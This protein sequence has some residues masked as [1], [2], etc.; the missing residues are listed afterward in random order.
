M[1]LCTWPIQINS[2]L[3]GFGTSG[4]E[5]PSVPRS[6]GSGSLWRKPGGAARVRGRLGPQSADLCGR[7]LP[8]FTAPQLIRDAN[9]C[10]VGVSSSAEQRS[11]LFFPRSSSPLHLALSARSRAL[12]EVLPPAPAVPL[13]PQRCRGAAQRSEGNA[14]GSCAPTPAEP[15]R[16]PR[17]GGRLARAGRFARISPRAKRFGGRVRLRSRLCLSK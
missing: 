2:R 1:C 15:R 12:A 13:P 5:S 7:D 16:L 6:E 8:D 9:I 11:N 14:P 10:T 3:N 4:R 17:A